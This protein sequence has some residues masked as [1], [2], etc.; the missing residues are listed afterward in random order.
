MSVKLA[1]CG[2]NPVVTRE[3][4]DFGTWP[5]VTEEDEKAILEVLHARSMSGTDVTLKLEEEY[6]E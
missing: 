4:P 5:I 1:I 6:A 3:S 2:G